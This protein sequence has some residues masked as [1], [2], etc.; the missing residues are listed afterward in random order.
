M[1]E[2]RTMPPPDGD[3]KPESEAVA[4]YVAS[5]VEAAGPG[6]SPEHV[7]EVVVAVIVDLEARSTGQEE[8]G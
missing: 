1:S 3:V 4:R 8:V 6:A 2:T 7:A 5:L